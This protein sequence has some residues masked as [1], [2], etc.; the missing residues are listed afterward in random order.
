[1]EYLLANARIY[2]MVIVFFSSCFIGLLSG[3]SLPMLAMRSIAIT[4]IVGVLGH[5]F[6]KYVESVAKTVLPEPQD[7]KESTAPSKTSHDSGKEKKK[8]LIEEKGKS[9]HSK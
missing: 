8:S 9:G 4:G 6:F 2:L 1:V 5:L 7:N 3:V